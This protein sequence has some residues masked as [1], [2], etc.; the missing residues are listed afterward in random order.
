MKKLSELFLSVVL[1]I[2]LLALP[3]SVQA[4]EPGTGLELS[5]TTHALRLVLIGLGATTLFIFVAIL[6]SP[7]KEST[8]H[9]LFNAIIIAVVTPTL[10]LVYNT[11]YLNLNSWSEGPVHWH[12]DYEVWVCGQKLDLV[13]PV[14]WS[15]KI[16][17]P[18]L[19]EHNDSR[20][21][22]EGVAIT[23]NDV[24]LGNFF[25]VIGGKI[26][27]SEIIFPDKSGLIDK[28]SG[29]LCPDGTVGTLQTYAYR[30]NK[31]LTY[32]QQKIH[33]PESYIISPESIVPPGDCII[34]EFG[35]QAPTTNRLCRSWEVGKMTGKLGQEVYDNRN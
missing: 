18:T 15:N 17:T 32:Y 33:F 35:P 31:D 11:V 2:F 1:A 20:I 24:S 16:G 5:M 22:L 34:V 10:V 14:G 9:F 6:L 3:L 7:K 28:T 23:P 27:S 21:H 4:G 25:T 8:K 19:H 30:A 29:T 12:A 26:T 13:D